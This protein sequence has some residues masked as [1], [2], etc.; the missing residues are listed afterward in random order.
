LTPQERPPRARPGPEGTVFIG[1]RRLTWRQTFVA[2]KYRN[3]RLWYLGQLVSLMG[4]WMQMTAQGYLVFELTKSPAFLGYVGFAA[5]AP[6]WLFMLYGGVVADRLPR[7]TLLICTQTA[8]M[9]LAFVLAA[10]SF[11]GVVRPWH[12]I[13][14]ASLMGVTMA[15]D[16]PARQAFVLELVARKDMANAIALNSTMFNSATAVGPAVAGVIYALFG[17]AWCFLVNAVSY[18]AIIVALLLMRIDLEPREARKVSTLAE[19]RE[20]VR[21][22]LHEPMIRTVILVV[23]ATSLF[24]FSFATLIPAWAVKILHGGATT[25]GYLQSARGVGAL[26]SALLIATLSHYHIKGKLLTVGTLVFPALLF[27]FSLARWFPLSLLLMFGVGAALIQIMNL[28]NALVQSLVLD[29]LR[30]RV[31]GLYGLT[32]FGL[33]PLGALWIGTVAEHMGEPTAVMVGATVSLTVAV[34]VLIRAPGLRRLP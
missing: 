15:F 7:R 32:F 9:S 10:L 6:T 28:A 8:M 25:N 18:S 14:L 23:G 17:P 26:L 30:G 29:R 2:F 13:V 12:I 33:M 24:G 1:K 22:A 19:L 4:S 20:G 21:Y 5:G 27:A 31:M 11:T 34:L 16:V 3:Y